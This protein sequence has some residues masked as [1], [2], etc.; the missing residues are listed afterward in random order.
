MKDSDTAEYGDEPHTWPEKLREAAAWFDTF[1]K[2]MGRLQVVTLGGTEKLLVSALTGG[3]QIQDDLRF[4]A[5][6]MERFKQ[7]DDGIV[8][9]YVVPEDYRPNGS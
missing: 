2:L 1:D 8:T 4:L 5:D 7:A 3:S 6:E 9:S